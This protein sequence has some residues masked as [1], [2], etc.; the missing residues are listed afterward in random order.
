MPRG[1][2][3]MRRGPHLQGEGQQLTEQRNTHTRTS[4]HNPAHPLKGSDI[5]CVA[6]LISTRGLKESQKRRKGQMGFLAVLPTCLIWHTTCQPQGANWSYS[7]ELRLSPVS[8][9][10][11][12][13]LG[14][15]NL[16]NL[17]IMGQI[18]RSC[19]RLSCALQNVELH[20]WSPPLHI[21]TT[22]LP[23]GNKQKSHCQ[24][25]PPVGNTH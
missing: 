10:Q 17:D 2:T 16:G 1:N 12:T 25:S 23:K 9:T 18:I 6:Q 5:N 14:F 24:K 19:E 20:P 21:S 4:R 7:A 15:L 13:R 3:R 11:L 22:A 8:G